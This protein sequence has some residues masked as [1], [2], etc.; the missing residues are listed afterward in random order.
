[1]KA[2]NVSKLLGAC[3]EAKRI[4]ELMPNFRKE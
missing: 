1:M 3:Y 4:V 2:E